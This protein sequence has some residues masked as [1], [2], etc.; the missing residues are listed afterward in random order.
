MIKTKLW[1]ILRDNRL[2]LTTIL[3]LMLACVYVWY[4]AFTQIAHCNQQ[5][6]IWQTLRRQASI[7]FGINGAEQY[8]SDKQHIVE[9][10]NTIP[11]HHEFPRVI[12]EIH[13]FMALH[14]ATPGTKSFKQLKTELDGIIA[15]SV[16]CS[17][18]GSYPGLKHLI[19]DLERL[20]GISTL[21]SFSLA[22]PDPSIE[23]VVLNLQLTIYLRE[24]QL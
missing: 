11:Y 10:Y 17:A 7:R 6:A 23:K 18:S 22:N 13:D 24:G 21:D 5:Q 14:G 9:L 15:Y 12:S 3:L 1:Q 2:I 19:A 20:D 8:I 16:D 4:E